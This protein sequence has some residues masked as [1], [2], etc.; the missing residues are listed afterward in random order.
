MAVENLI[1]R[2]KKFLQKQGVFDKRLRFFKPVADNLSL[3]EIF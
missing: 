2:V 1:L 3:C